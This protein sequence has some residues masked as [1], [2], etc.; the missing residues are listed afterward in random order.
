[1]NGILHFFRPCSWGQPFFQ[2]YTLMNYGNRHL[3][4]ML[5]LV[6]IKSLTGFNCNKKTAPQKKLT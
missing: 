1:M 4:K 2:A 5:C 3:A 6:E